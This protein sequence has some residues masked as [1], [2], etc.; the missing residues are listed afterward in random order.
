MSR[1][2]FYGLFVTVRYFIR[3]L[4]DCP[5]LLLQGNCPFLSF[6]FLFWLLV[7]ETNLKFITV[8]FLPV[9]LS[10]H[11]HFSSFLLTE[12]KK[13]LLIAE[14]KRSVL[15]HVDMETD[16]NK[17]VPLPIDKILG[18][19]AVGFDPVDQKIYYGEVGRSI[20]RRSFLNGTA[21]ET[22]INGV[23]FANRL[24]IDYINRNIYYTDTSRNKIDV[25]ALSGL[26]RTTLLFTTAPEGIALDLKN[27]YVIF[28]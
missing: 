26:H 19:T 3:F 25:A 28:H 27:G 6:M 10:L 17:A 23:Y 18:L 9:H 14:Y 16:P 8:L 15:Y 4:R 12:S 2:L 11:L 21:D 22:I 1:I 24:A 5:P 13:S 7:C 20:I